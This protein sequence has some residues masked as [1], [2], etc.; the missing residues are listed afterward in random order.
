MAYGSSA[1][2]GAKGKKPYKKVYR[3]K[4][5][6]MAVANKALALAKKN[7]KLAYGSYQ[8]QLQH[9]FRSLQVTRDTPICFNLTTPIDDQPIFQ[10]LPSVAGPYTVQTVSSFSHPNLQQMTGGN[11]GGSQ[12]RNFWL[13]CND[14]RF[15]GKYK[16]L[17]SNY[18]FRLRADTEAQ[19]N[20][21]SG[22]KVRIDFYK[23]KW[24]R[25]MKYDIGSGGVN[26]R[27]LQLPDA[28]GS[29]NGLMA[30][31]NAVNPMYWNKIGKSHYIT[32]DTHNDRTTAD[33]ITKVWMKHNLVMNPKTENPSN[34]F[35]PNA[36]I[37][38]NKQLWCVISSDNIRDENNL[39]QLPVL[40]IKRIVSW[41][42]GVGHA[43]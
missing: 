1:P 2:K 8:I 27:V 21:T 11:S 23:P 36:N 7:N 43:A 22:T 30:D 38:I 19:K 33:V 39:N 35:E 31:Y 26:T 6:A 18:E 29:F 12:D 16:L 24:N 9:T 34:E 40:T 15:N 32:L 28:L 25:V 13:D 4:S 41:R 20:Y 42:D 17:N 5:S 10:W 37:P 3:K 14:D